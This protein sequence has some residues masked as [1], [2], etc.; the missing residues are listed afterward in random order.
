M[1]SNSSLRLEPV[2]ALGMNILPAGTVFWNASHQFFYPVGAHV[3]HYHLETNHSQFLFNERFTS[4]S[5]KTV[6]IC[7][8]AV[9]SNG[10]F[11]A[12]SEVIHPNRGIIS[13]YDFETQVTHIRLENPGTKKWESVVFSSDSNIIAAIGIGDKDNRIFIWKLGRQVQLADI[14]PISNDI[15][16]ISFDPQD[17]FRL[18]LVSPTKIFTLIT[19]TIDKQINPVEISG[20]NNFEKYSFVPSVPGLLLISSGNFLAVIL[21]KDL[22]EII[23]PSENSISFIK[24]VRS[25]VFIIC[26]NEILLY[27]ANSQ[28]PLLSFIGPIEIEFQSILDFSPSPDGDQAIILHDDSYVSL[29]DIGVAQK[30]IKQ[31]SE[32]GLQKPEENNLSIDAPSQ[33]ELNQFLG[34]TLHFQYDSIMALWFRLEHVLKNLF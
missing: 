13:I 28:Q 23:T 29:I 24:C 10:Q 6:E 5:S 3:R 22:I 1:A 25:Y 19:N 18:L 31:K 27:R 30:I 34:L 16:S 20:L 17:P 14:I 33:A 8:L 9:T 2:L 4:S 12:I 26:R 21:D 32:G 11:I 7:E 15:S